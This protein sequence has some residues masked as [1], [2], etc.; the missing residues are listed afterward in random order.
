MSACRELEES[1]TGDTLRVK[2]YTIKPLAW[3]HYR[4]DY[5]ELYSAR[6]G[7]GEYAVVRYCQHGV[8]G[9]W[10]VKPFAASSF[11]AECA[12]PEAGK[13]LAEQHWR[14]YMKQGLIEQ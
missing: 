5:Q 10:K 6:A 2:T 9:D 12:S 11:M 8:W 1:T 13:Q 4:Y 14:E 3:R 7:N